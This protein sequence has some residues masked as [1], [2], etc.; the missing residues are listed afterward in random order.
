MWA[1]Y[2][3][4]WPYLL[5]SRAEAALT[6]GECARSA[7]GVRRC[8]KYLGTNYF[9][10]EMKPRPVGTARLHG[11]FPYSTIRGIDVKDDDAPSQQTKNKK[12]KNENFHHRHC[13][14]H[15]HPTPPAS[16]TTSTPSVPPP[17]SPT[18]TPPSPHNSHPH[19]YHHHHCHCQH[20]HR[21]SPVRTAVCLRLLLLLSETA[22]S[23]P[24]TSVHA[25]PGQPT[26]RC[27]PRMAE[28]R[29]E[30]TT[31]A[32]QRQS[33]AKQRA[34]TQIIAEQSRKQVKA[35]PNKVKAEQGR[36]KQAK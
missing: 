6:A 27:V 23:S 28:D 22:P 34:E 21:L 17:R 30:G 11:G 13:H 29:P 26:D 5:H 7:S 32:S 12:T 16:T 9:V 15:Q 1:L 33:K 20:Q 36:A 19:R 10:C 3:L 2:P 35:T 8:K 4:L 18:P 14:Q 24:T 25:S 31:S